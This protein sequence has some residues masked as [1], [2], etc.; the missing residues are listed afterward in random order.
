MKSKTKTITIKTNEENP[1]PLEVLAS[2]IITISDG[3]DK[4][5]KSSLSRKAVVL[6]IHELTRVPKGHIEAILN[7]APLLA[8]HY[9]KPAGK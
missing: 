3:F 8:K 2:A 7:A 9:T 6:L 4:I 5:N 1:E